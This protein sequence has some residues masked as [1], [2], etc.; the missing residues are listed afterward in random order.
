VFHHILQRSKVKHKTHDPL[1]KACRR[2]WPKFDDKE[3][4]FKRSGKMGG[5]A[6]V[7]I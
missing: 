2:I 1:K 7:Q 4:G 5:G 6:T 3:V